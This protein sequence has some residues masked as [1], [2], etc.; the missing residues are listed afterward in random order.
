MNWT[1]KKSGGAGI[2]VFHGRLS[3]DSAYEIK[4]AIMKYISDHDRIFFDFRKVTEMDCSLIK[5]FCE[6]CRISR[7]LGK[8]PVLLGLEEAGNLVEFTPPILSRLTT[9]GF[10]GVETLRDVSTLFSNVF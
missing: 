8:S 10:P 2:L 9:E 5:V 4:H 7:K 6:A 1:L 3:S